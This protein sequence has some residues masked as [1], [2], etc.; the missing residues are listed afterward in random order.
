MADRPTLDGFYPRRPNARGVAVNGGG[1]MGFNEPESSHYRPVSKGVQMLRPV[2]SAPTPKDTYRVP[3]AKENQPALAL[4]AQPLQPGVH[5]S[6]LEESLRDIDQDKPAANRD[7]SRK[8]WRRNKNKV[9]V[10]SRRKKVIWSIVIVAVVLLLA[11]AGYVFSKALFASN[12]IFNGDIFGLV[13]QKP[14]QQDANGR[15]N[16]L[17]VGTSEDDPGHQGANLT[18][19]IIVLSIDQSAKNAYMVSIPRDLRVKYG[20]SCVP[21]SYGKINVFFSCSADG[22]TKEAEQAR[23]TAMRQFVGNIVGLNIQYS[24]HVNYSV[25]RDVVGAIGN[26]TVNIEGSGGAPGVM[27]SNFDWKCKGGNAYASLATMK[28][29]CPPNGHFIDYPNGPAT[30]D[31]EHALY[32]AQARGDSVPTYG[33]GRSNFDRELNQ[34]KIIKAIKEKAMSTGTITN[35]VAVTNLIDAMGNNLRTNFDTSEIRTLM[36]LTKDTP[37]DAVQSISLVDADPALFGSDGEGNVAPLAGLY[38][39]SSIKSYIQKKINATPVTKEAAHVVVLNASGVAGVAKAE[40]D[41]LTALGMNI[42]TVGN[43]PATHYQ[44][45]MIYQIKKDGSDGKP[46]TAKKLQEIYGVAL[47]TDALPEGIVVGAD[48]E[49]VVVVVKPTITPATATSN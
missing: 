26:I 47:A 28:K 19:S 23:Q 15:T 30:L 10:H 48:T 32:L 44:S 20:M 2:V 31:A 33:L 7:P 39:Y 43:A 29:N 36:T 24:A 42:D 22:D 4:A 14:L 12:H 13:Q 1:G 27:D 5:R 41:K 40:G 3:Y 8:R 9:K 18:D 49:F 46:N 16:I 11:G 45:N 25:V 21:G 17:L 38:D 35:V 6:E 37:N 34:Q